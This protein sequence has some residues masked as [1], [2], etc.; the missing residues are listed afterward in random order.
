MES[1]HGR[2]EFGGPQAPAAP[3]P[4]PAARATDCG[5][6][7]L[8]ADTLPTQPHSG[9]TADAFQLPRR[10][11]RKRPRPR[12]CLDPDRRAGATPL[13]GRPPC[14]PAV[15]SQQCLQGRSSHLL[16]GS[17]PQGCVR[18]T[19]SG[20]WKSLAP[21]LPRPGREG[22]RE[23][24]SRSGRQGR[25]EAGAPGRGTRPTGLC[26]APLAQALGSFLQDRP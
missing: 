11:G 16:P 4:C 14:L 12:I 24:Q 3:P 21:P 10:L 25:R 2:L 1:V 19:C 22:G 17:S 7:H 9:R 23:T 13:P 15:A 26:R 18:S 20:S 5:H 8:P 6:G